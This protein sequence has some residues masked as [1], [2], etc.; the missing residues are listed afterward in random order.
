M[1]PT[2]EAHDVFS[3]NVKQ[4]GSRSLPAVSVYAVHRPDKQWA[5]LA[6]NKHPRHA[7][8][9]TAQFKFSDTQ[10]PMSLAD[11]VEVI[12]FS[13]QQ[14]TWHDDGPNGHPLRSM[15]P[16]HFR[17]A[18]SRFYDLPPYSLTIIRGKVPEP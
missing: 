13:R 11:Q 7:A 12:Q 10:P 18:A 17:G 8:R 15:P 3:V 1:Q 6:I 5:L 4:R 16:S 14:Y 9:L 2:N